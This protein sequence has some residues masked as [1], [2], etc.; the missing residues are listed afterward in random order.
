MVS[1]SRTTLPASQLRP[2]NTPRRIQVDAGEN[3]IP[4]IVHGCPTA[5]INDQWRIDDEWWRQPISRRYF[6][7]ILVDGCCATL[8]QDLLTK[9]WYR[10]SY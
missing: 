2:L 3:G 6:R 5:E 1:H 7:V 10:Q 9:D 8:Y 4:R